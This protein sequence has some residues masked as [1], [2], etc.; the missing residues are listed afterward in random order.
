MTF[1]N[2][3]GHRVS[4]GHLFSANKALTGLYLTELLDT[5]SHRN[6]QTTRLLP[7]LLATFPRLTAGPIAEDTTYTSL[8]P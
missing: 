8:W 6:H 1:S 3:G 5:G 2:N 4:T 7:G